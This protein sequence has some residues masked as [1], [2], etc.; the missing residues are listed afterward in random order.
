VMDSTT[1]DSA[2]LDTAEFGTGHLSPLIL[3]QI[4]GRLGSG[5]GLRV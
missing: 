3:S 5:S 2:G 4:K 1:M